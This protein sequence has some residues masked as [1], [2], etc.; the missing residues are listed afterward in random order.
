VNSPGSIWVTW[1]FNQTRSRSGQTKFY[2]TRILPL[3]GSVMAELRAYIDARRRAGAPQ[4]PQSGLFWHEHFN[5][6]YTP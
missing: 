6:H 4:D 3:T 5:D 1:T 2:K